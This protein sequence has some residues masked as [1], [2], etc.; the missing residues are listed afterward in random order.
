MRGRRV[1]RGVAE[2]SLAKRLRSV[3]VNIVGVG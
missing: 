2:G 3:G 1:V